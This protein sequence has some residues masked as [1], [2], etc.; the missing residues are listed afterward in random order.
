VPCTE[1][2]PLCARHC[3]G[4]QVATHLRCDLAPPPPTTLTHL[5]THALPQCAAQKAHLNNYVGNS[6]PTPLSDC[7]Q[8]LKFQAL[9]SEPPRLSVTA[10]VPHQVDVGIQGA[11][12]KETI[13]EENV[14][15]PCTTLRQICVDQPNISSRRLNE[16]PNLARN[17]FIVALKLQ[18][19]YRPMVLLNNTCHYSQHVSG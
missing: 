6:T 12:T 2:N 16:S 11:A 4:P 9:V 17:E 8:S 19:M 13:L 7:L 18:I 3:R 14:V 5:G 1:G 10:R 15:A